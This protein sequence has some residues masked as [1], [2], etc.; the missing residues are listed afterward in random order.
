[1]N[2]QVTSL[3]IL[4]DEPDIR[5]E[6]KEYLCTF[7]YEV[8]LAS[9]PGEA[10][11][12]LAQHPVNIAILDIR[13]P[14]MNGIEVLK[15]IRKHYPCTQAIMMSG[16]G[17]M[18]AAISALRL[19][20][21]DFFQKPF[22]LNELHQTIEKVRKVISFSEPT[23]TEQFTYH[24]KK[25]SGG[26][27]TFSF[28]A[29]S[30]SMKEIVAKMSKVARTKDTT[31]L[32]TGESG[33]GKELI[34]KGIHYLSERKEQPF[35][36]V[37]C[38]SIPDELFESEFFGYKKGAFTGAVND[39]PGWF[40]SANGG[41]LFL[42]EIGDLK[43]SLQAKLLRVM[44]EKEVCRLGCNSYK[45]IDVRVIAATNQDLEQMISEKKFRAD[46]Y[47]RLNGFVINIPAL[48][49]TKEGIP[50][51]FSHYL[52][53]FANKLGR[54]VPGVETGIMNALM[55]YDFP[56]N[57]RELKHMIERALIVCEGDTLTPD[58]FYPLDL[59]LQQTGISAGA[60]KLYES[61][62]HMERESIERTLRDVRFN[63]SQAA[64]LLQIS[65]QSLDR[66]LSKYGI[67]VK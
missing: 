12:I 20:A 43:M 55:R 64:R 46:L 47:Y 15:E 3:L 66:K 7:G 21:A 14:E 26:D 42:D 34:A 28:I 57:V 44:E 19:G 40:E 27:S 41:T 24:I 48:R 2:P 18:D 53:Y 23:H 51:L 11:E 65:R 9:R 33:T 60:G 61:L 36:A 63:K 10:F 22:L 54:P 35:H 1:M 25:A 59:K 17:D 32:V 29:V 49:N 45:K 8:Y 56:G 52:E 16:Y 6:I 30:P 31:V 37:N 62:D 4:D 58:H 39:K 5:T 67:Q 38:S 50:K 13:L